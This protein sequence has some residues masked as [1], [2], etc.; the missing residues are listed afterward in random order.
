MPD[1]ARE[2]IDVHD[3]VTGGLLALAA[4]PEEGEALSPE[5]A[6]AALP[7][8]YDVYLNRREISVLRG[9]GKFV[10]LAAFNAAG[11][12]AVTA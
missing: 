1:L 12:M 7:V 10:R 9:H 3:M 4:L 11:T 8:L 6:A 2:R 5:T